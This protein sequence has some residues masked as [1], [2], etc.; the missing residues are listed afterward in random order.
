VFGRARPALLVDPSDALAAVRSR[1]QRGCDDLV[2]RDS[3][4]NATRAAGRRVRTPISVRTIGIVA[5]DVGERRIGPSSGRLFALLLYLTLRRG[6]ATSRRVVQELLFPRAEDGHASHSLRQL[7]YRLRQVGVP[8]EADADQIA[9][10]GEV[11]SVDW[12][13]LVDSRVVSI[14]DVE[15]LTHGVFPGYSAEVSE[16]YREWFEAERADICL[17]LSRSLTIQLAQ[18]RSAGRWDAV[19]AAAKALLS[20]DPLSEEG[21]LARAEMLAI[22]GSKSAA[23]G[24]IDDYLHELGETQ[25]HLRLAPSALRRRISERV[26]DASQRAADDRIFIGREHA[27]Q[28]LSA[29]GAS[30]RAGGQQVLLVWGEPG[31]GKTRLLSEYRALASLQ[32]GIAPLLSCQPHDVFRPLGILC[33][34]VAQLLQ[35]P[36]ALGCDPEARALLDRLVSA[37]THVDSRREAANAEAPLSAIVRSMSDLATAIASECAIQI[38]I[39]DAQWVDR[40]SL[41]AL[42]GAFA[43]RSARRTCVILAS[44]DRALLAGADSYS[45]S[46]SAV[47]L[48]PLERKA[49]LELTRSL[50]NGAS[51]GDTTR[52]EQ[53]V[54]EQARG[55][56]LFIRLFCAHFLTTN[57]S[58]SLK[59]TVQ[60]ILKRRLEQ[61][62]QE[63]TRTLEACVV[64]A[65]NCT[66]G[67]LEQ[68]LEIPA[69]RLLQAIEELDDRGL[70]E[71]SDGFIVSSHALLSDAVTHRMSESVQRVLHAAAADLLQRDVDPSQAGRLPWDCAEHWRLAGNDA[72]AI[73]VL[74]ACAQ[75]ALEVGRPTDAL[76]TFNRALALRSPD[77][78]RLELVECALDTVWSGINFGDAQELLSE[79]KRLR[80]RLGLPLVAHDTYEILE[81]A[82]VLHSDRDPRIT[83][84]RLRECVTDSAA[85]VRHKL[86]AAGQLIMIA[87][88]TIDSELAEFALRA[89]SNLA[90]GSFGRAVCDLFYHACFGSIEETSTIARQ[91]TTTCVTD[92]RRQVAMLLNIG[93]AYYRIGNSAD[94]S[95][96]LMQALE[97][98][99]RNEL[100]SA[101]MYA[102]SFLAQL[103]WSIEQIDDCR[104]WHDRLAELVSREVASAVI[105]DYCILGARMAIH[106]GRHATVRGFID[107]ARAC[108]QSQL[109]AHRM[110]L[111]AC[112]VELRLATGEEACSDSE[113]HALLSLHLRARHLGGQDEVLVA[114]LHALQARRQSVAAISL[115]NGYRQHRRAG[116]PIRTELARVSA[117]LVTHSDAL[118]DGGALA[119]DEAAPQDVTCA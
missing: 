7:L 87:D 97:A 94:A 90:P 119:N 59:H 76:A 29:M 80:A 25:P 49:A 30:A 112:E 28:M 107:R 10:P 113:L 88:L 109:D 58:E 26:P 43:G 13:D 14:A 31:I 12:C 6:H 44:R 98:A 20:L 55:N 103:N 5:I 75:R 110:H 46:V 40:N 22:A 2:T 1:V 57:D 84:P 32:G 83:I 16:S 48:N 51:H 21:T 65:K 79:L 53:H 96:N 81:F 64:L 101:E 100:I 11:V 3:H 105:C 27:M 114:L 38:L 77:D 106:D 56:P 19:N 39:D 108:A 82:R 8:I 54:I 61:L 115:L 73:S 47:R 36:G 69:H 24:I 78:I 15:L 9:V 35:A 95:Q 4:P 74:R 23:L 60:D 92:P 33:D 50:M 71:V 72:Q 66:F 104:V 62:S 111:L 37:S 34:L 93:Y 68:L 70:I 99:R 86:N 18:F 17:R 116:F 118:C 63:A 52:I 41:R 102:L 67:R 117:E 89:T 45:D 91:M 85:T 42:L